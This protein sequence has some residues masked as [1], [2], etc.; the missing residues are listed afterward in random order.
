MDFS[1]T[2]AH[3]IG[4][5]VK[6]IDEIRK[7]RY[8]PSEDTLTLT[9]E[10]IEALQEIEN[11]WNRTFRDGDK[12]YGFLPG[13]IKSSDDRKNLSHF[14]FWTAWAS[15]TNR[16]EKSYSYTNNWPPDK[17]VGNT[18]PS[19]VLIWSFG[20]ILGFFT[21]LGIIIY[22]V[23]RYRILYGEPRGVALAEKIYSM[24]LTHSQNKAAKFFL[25]VV[26]LFIIQTLIGGL[27]AHYTISPAHFY[28]PII[29]KIIPYSLAKSWHLQLAI[30]WIATTW[31]GT[32]IYLA[33]IIGG[34]EPKGQGILV[35]LLFGAVIIVAAGSLLG[36]ILGIKDKLG[37]LWY[38]FGHQ[39]WEYLE[40]GRAWQILLFIGLVAWLLIVYRAIAKQLAYKGNDDYKSL[41]TFYVFSAILVVVFFGFGFFY[42]HGT[43]LTV[44]D[45]WRWFV[46]HIWVEGIFEFFGVAIISL[47]LVILGLVERKSALTVAYFT[48]ILVFASGIIGTAHHYFWYGGPAYWLALGSI[49]SSLEPIPL[50]LLV[51]RAWMEYSSIKRQGKE[52]P[53]RWP[54]F[55]LVASSFWNF[56]GAGVFGFLINLPIINYYEH[57]TYLTANHGHTAL[58]GVYGMLSISLLTFSWRGLIDNKYWSDKLLKISFFGL[59]TGLLTMSLLTLLPI[60]IAQLLASFEKGLWFAR[61]AAFYSG[62]LVQFL[63]KIRI[64]PDMIIIILGVIPLAVFLILTYPHIRKAEIHEE[65]N[66]WQRIGIS[67]K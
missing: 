66:I 8:N 57:G 34:K 23:H 50:I 51:V 39:G 18:P 5:R 54:L 16:P 60:G 48:A 28:I 29:G 2:T 33:P 56:L 67:I 22:L 11:Y 46:V 32:A 25:L 6:I 47:F 9:T 35:T 14:F 13:T 17:S 4:E 65:E 45:Y 30:F 1:A 52:F 62:Q 19:G 63:G 42:N 15:I 53:Y 31:I 38:W 59:N 37:K 40:L 3:I 12:N 55:F 24:P 64:L 61:S 21:I 44:A 20:G 26:L 7:N 36:E 41:V 49:F 10:Q 58:F 27:L 43:H